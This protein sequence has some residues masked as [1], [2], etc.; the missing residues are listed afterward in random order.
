M[1]GAGILSLRRRSSLVVEQKCR[2]PFAVTRLISTV[3]LPNITT[4]IPMED[5]FLIS[6]ALQPMRKRVGIIAA[7]GNL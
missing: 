5:S 6:A 3:D 1:H 7:T 2:P 4:T